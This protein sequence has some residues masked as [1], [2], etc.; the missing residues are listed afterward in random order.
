[1]LLLQR[2]PAGRDSSHPVVISKV[3]GPKGEGLAKARNIHYKADH[4]AAQTLASQ[5]LS[6]A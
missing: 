3:P 6:K 4:S 1:M 5:A 2:G